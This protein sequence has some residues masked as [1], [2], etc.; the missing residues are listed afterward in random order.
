MCG[1]QHVE[2]KE[3][4]KKQLNNWKTRARGHKGG[5]PRSCAQEKVYLQ[6]LGP[7]TYAARTPKATLVRVIIIVVIN[8]S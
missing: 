3:T 5:G 6:K 1:P 8:N 7:L 2:N 4:L